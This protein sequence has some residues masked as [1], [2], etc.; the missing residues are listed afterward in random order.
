VVGVFGKRFSE[1]IN[2]FQ[3]HVI[4]EVVHGAAAILD[5][6]HSG[7]AR[8]S[9]HGEN[10]TSAE[11]VFTVMPKLMAQYVANWR[12]FARKRLVR[13][14]TRPGNGTLRQTHSIGGTSNRWSHSF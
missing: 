13:I 1:T 7:F 2:L 14:E 6:P 12:D 4:R 5:R 8:F 10:F 11:Q 9:S 3:P